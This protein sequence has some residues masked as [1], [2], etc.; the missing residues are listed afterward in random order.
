MKKKIIKY[1][2]IF[3]ITINC[4]SQT[5]IIPIEIDGEWG[6]TKG[7]YYKDTN[8]Y[9]SP[10]LG[11]WVYYDGI[12]RLTLV[13]T[14]REMIHSNFNGGFYTDMVVGEYKYEVNGTVL[15][16]T[17]NNINNIGY[18]VNSI[19]GINLIKP[20]QYPPCTDCDVNEKRLNLVFKNINATYLNSYIVIRKKVIAGV[21][22]LEIHKFSRDS[23]QP[24]NEFT[25]E[26][27]IVV[28]GGTYLLKQE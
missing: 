12:T 9:Y 3:F 24:G 17:I 5:P 14:K 25:D 23:F 26:E 8:N 2:F 28:P 16:N 18:R 6:D 27:P 19:S 15:I 11:T 7:A 13:L 4:K 20:F 21:N 1:I 10:F 22:Y